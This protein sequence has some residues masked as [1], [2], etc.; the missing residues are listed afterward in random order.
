MSANAGWNKLNKAMHTLREKWDLTE[1]DWRDQVREE[2]SR[3]HV[4]PVQLQVSS[5]LR[6]IKR[7][8]EVL[9]RIR[10]ECSAS[11]EY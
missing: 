6:G 4:E 3:D 11:R 5:T 10:R 7:L 1:A 9:S 2:F 8:E